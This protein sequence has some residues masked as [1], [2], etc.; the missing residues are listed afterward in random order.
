MSDDNDEGYVNAL[1]ECLNQCKAKHDQVL[2]EEVKVAFDKYDADGSGSI[3]KE[4][5]GE[6]IKELGNE[7]TDDELTNA[8]KSLDVNKDGVIDLEEFAW[9]Y[10]SGMKDLTGT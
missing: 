4:E 6:L 3:D 8:L 9:W 10:F 5:L 2:Q 1:K 7:L